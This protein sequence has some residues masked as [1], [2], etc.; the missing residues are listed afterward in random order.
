MH[1]QDKKN[2]LNIIAI[3]VQG[4]TSPAGTVSP[5]LPVAC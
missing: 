2:K 1:K 5:L 3:G 4:A